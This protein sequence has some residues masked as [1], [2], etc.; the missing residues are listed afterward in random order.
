MAWLSWTTDHL[1]MKLLLRQFSSHTFANVAALMQVVWTVQGTE[2][3]QLRIPSTVSM[4]HEAPLIQPIQ[5]YV[6]MSAIS[7]DVW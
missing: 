2:K 4:A 6:Q 7:Y 5:E 3:Q 1:R